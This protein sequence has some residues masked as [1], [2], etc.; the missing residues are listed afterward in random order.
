VADLETRIERELIAAAGRAGRLRYAR[1]PLPRPAALAATA[2]SIVLVIGV[3][4]AGIS[5]VSEPPAPRPALD[6]RPV[7]APS[8]QAKRLRTL[9]SPKPAPVELGTSY[10]SLADGKVHEGPPVPGATVTIHGSSTGGCIAVMF[11][12]DLGPG[13]S[14]FTVQ[15]VDAGSLRFTLSGLM[16]VLVPDEATDITLKTPDG[17]RQPTTATSNLVIATPSDTVRYSAGGKTITVTASRVSS[18]EA[19][20]KPLPTEAPLVTTEPSPTDTP[21]G[22]RDDNEGH[23]GTTTNPSSSFGGWTGSNGDYTIIIEATDNLTDAEGVAEQAEGKGLTVGIL[24]SDDYTS[25]PAGYHVVFSGAYSTKLDA[26][27]NLDAVR[28]SFPDAYVRQVRA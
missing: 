24:N 10:S 3:I 21:L 14:C 8:P 9:G 23:T 25:M 12:G 13:G 1:S 18:T 17:A 4:A 16:V 28:A 11:D 19:P 22:P 7:T 6:E 15:N 26:Q 2:A 20:R 27:N 5:V